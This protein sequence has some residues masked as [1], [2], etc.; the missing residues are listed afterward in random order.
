MPPSLPDGS[1]KDQ[2]EEGGGRE[3]MLSAVWKA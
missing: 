3:A 1:E 2:Q